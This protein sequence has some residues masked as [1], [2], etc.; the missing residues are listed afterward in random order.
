MDMTAIQI[1]LPDG[2]W[3]VEQGEDYTAKWREQFGGEVPV[4]RVFQHNDKRTAMVGREPY[5]EGDWRWHISVRSG[6]PGIDG[7]IPSWDELVDT[8]HALRPGVPFVI[9]IPPR[10]YWMNHHPH[11]LHIVETKDEAMINNW[12]INSQR[13]R[14]VP[15]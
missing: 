12:R 8:A 7:R 14:D 3:E 5:A 10:S 11:V 9:G 6:D 2:W 4:P 1:K 13:G 15:T